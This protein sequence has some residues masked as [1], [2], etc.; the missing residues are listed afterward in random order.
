M[1]DFK[2]I[3]RLGSL[4][5]PYAEEHLGRR[6]NIFCKVELKDG[7]LSISGVEG[8][9]NSGNAIGSCGQID[10]HL[11][12]AGGL[13]GFKPAPEWSLSKV[14]HFLEVW[15]RWHLNDM[16]AYDSEMQAAGW[17]ELARTP[18][19]GFKFS[20]TL[21]SINAG[22]AAKEAA[23][24]ALKAGRPFTP[25]PEQVAAAS[26]PYSY[27]VWIREGEAEPEPLAGY[28][29]A[30]R[31][32][33]GDIESPERKTL[34]WLKPSEHPDGLLT[35][36]LRPDGDGYGCKW[37]R[38]EVPQAVLDFLKSLPESDMTPAWI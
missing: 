23:L 22:N 26:L 21:E 34:G 36:K 7:R 10:M 19:L 5:H 18:M 30:T 25:T 35:R 17:P 15:D 32:G 4:P 24:A 8:P 3:V 20:L 13:D 1:T 2:R 12:E 9:L 14:R 16:R 31:I 27:T 6:M 33:S 38:D 28:K 29:R 11:R 37:F